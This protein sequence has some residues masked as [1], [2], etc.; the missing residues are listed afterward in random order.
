ML[1]NVEVVD[2]ATYDDHL[3]DLEEQGNV[4]LVLGGQD[5]TTQAGL[6]DDTAEGDSE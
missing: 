6:E 4:G 1:F 2:R 5:A 3:R